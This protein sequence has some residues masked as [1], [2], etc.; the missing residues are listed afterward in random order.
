MHVSLI[1]YQKFCMSVWCSG[2]ISRVLFNL[3]IQ[4]CT[5]PL[6]EASRGGHVEIVKELLEHTA[7]PNTR[8]DVSHGQYYFEIVYCKSWLFSACT[9]K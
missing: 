1:V 5:T 4:F 3:I 6:L 9:Y 7:D 2:I 8:D